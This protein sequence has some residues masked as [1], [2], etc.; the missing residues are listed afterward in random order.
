MTVKIFIR[1]LF[2]KEV[3]AHVKHH[4]WA[5]VVSTLAL[6]ISLMGFIYGL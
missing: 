3:D 1:C 4:C 2:S 5:V 6:L